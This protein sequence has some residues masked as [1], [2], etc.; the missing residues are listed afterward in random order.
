MRKAFAQ[1][2]PV[3]ALCYFAFV[4]GFGMF[5]N[6]PI[7]VALSLVCALACSFVLR[8]GSGRLLLMIVPLGLITMVINPLFS[9]EGATILCY[10]PGGNPLTLESVCYGL[11]A[12]A[13]LAA[14]VLWFALLNA[15]LTSDKFIYLF[16][17][18]VPAL[19][20]VLSMALGFISRFAAQMGK[21]RRAQTQLSGNIGKKGRTKVALRQFSILITWSLED[22]LGTAD[23]MRSR[24]YGLRGRTAFSIYR[25]TL[26]DLGLLA[27]IL[28]A[29]TFVL[30]GFRVF[31]WS[32]Y[33]VMTGFSFEPYSVSV[34]LMYAALCLTPAVFGLWEEHRWRSLQSGI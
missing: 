26:R 28:F 22:A 3:T 15:V 12:G 23:S 10:L 30:V 2:H 8:P 14:V 11:G 32:Y 4:L 17:R 20:L 6:N 27:W 34:Y 1:C 7:C 19:S 25:W 13:M 24:G 18:I 16:G 29:G 5:C 9:H 21:I 31:S 33:P